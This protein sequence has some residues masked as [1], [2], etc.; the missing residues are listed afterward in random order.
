MYLPIIAKQ[1]LGKNVTVAMNIY[2]RIGE[3]LDASFLC[4]LCHIT[5]S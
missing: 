5:G 2:A 3:L 1:W 4:G